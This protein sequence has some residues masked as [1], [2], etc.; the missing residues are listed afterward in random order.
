V[1][2][3]NDNAGDVCTL[4]LE[5]KRPKGFCNISYQTRAILMIFGT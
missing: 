3:F 1:K 5:K 2:A 4:F